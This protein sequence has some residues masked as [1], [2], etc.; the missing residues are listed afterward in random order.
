MKKKLFAVILAALALTLVLAGFALAQPDDISFDV[1]VNPASTL[2][3]AE[4]SFETITVDVIIKNNSPNELT[5]IKVYMT[6]DTS[7]ERISTLASLASGASSDKLTLTIKLSASSLGVKKPLYV[8]Y[9]LGGTPQDPYK[10]YDVKVDKIEQDMKANITAIPVVSGKENI[11][12]GPEGAEVYFSYKVENTGNVPITQLAIQENMAYINSDGSK[13]EITTKILSDKVSESNP[14]APG[15]SINIQGHTAPLTKNIIVSPVMTFGD[16]GDSGEK[17]AD[18]VT[19]EKYAPK[20]EFS[21]TVDKTS[22]PFGSTTML[23]YSLRNTGNVT[24]SNISI[25]NESGDSIRSIASLTSGNKVTGERTITVTGTKNYKYTISA[26]TPDGKAFTASASVTVNMV[27]IDDTD[28]KVGLTVSSDKMELSAPGKI[29]LTIEIT[30]QNA[31]E[32]N[33]IEI[34]DSRDNVIETIS[35]LLSDATKT[36]QHEM[37]IAVTEDVFVCAYIPT[38]PDADAPKAEIV[39]NMLVISMGGQAEVTPS[40]SDTAPAPTASPSVSPS[41]SPETKTGLGIIDILIIGFIVI[42]VLVAIAVAALITINV[43][44]KKKKSKTRQM[45][46]RIK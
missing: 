44:D 20:V 12:A 28:I 19:V 8:S 1:T 42:L 30:N 46:R 45:N 13:T 40:P 2:P 9:T 7:E 5:D 37:D 6:D 34:K 10:I 27:P 11:T 16:S 26:K 31:F 17:K 23:H 18:P 15:A 14:L 39:S 4:G 35:S 29:I 25:K 32:L 43:M 22:V 21:L 36:I 24:L 33:N 38:G 3:P 41:S